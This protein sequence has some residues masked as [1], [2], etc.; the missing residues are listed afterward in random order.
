MRLALRRS[1]ALLAVALVAL[2][3]GIWVGS[4]AASEVPSFEQMLGLSPQT[5]PIAP[6]APSE[7]EGAPTAVRAPEAEGRPSDHPEAA[8]ASV[9]PVPEGF[10][11]YS[12][13]WIHFA[14]QP[15]SRARVEPLKAAADGVRAELR[16]I[17]GQDVL[18]R[19]HVRVGRTVGEMRTL[20]PPGTGFPK[21][22]SGVAYSE[23]GLVLLSEQSRYPN[24][25]HDLLQVFRHELAHVALHDAVG[26][27][28]VPRWF[29]EGFAVHAS[30]E[31]ITARMQTLWTATLAGKLLP[32]AELT[33]R[34]PADGTT[35]SVAYAQA[36]DVVRY[37]LRTHEAHRFRALIERLRSG[38]SFEAALA[39]AY[40]TDLANLEYEWREDVARRY[41]FWPVL[42]SGTMVW[43]GAILLVFWGWKRR[44]ARNQKILARWAVEE[45]AEDARLAA[46]TEVRP[47]HIVLARPSEIPPPPSGERP[48]RPDVPKIEHDGNWHTLH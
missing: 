7:Q 18:S 40:A 43:M 34:F 1:L 15:A 16:E 8:G 48:G 39:D 19:A 25:Q 2:L 10:S 27:Q 36:A 42:F 4:A 32:L 44:R 24:D 26:R 37:L 6:F 23:I 38:Q 31:A 45:A 13:G 30:G 5:E 28:N 17:L 9:P 29:N 46:A 12:A 21:Y 3:G 11:S 20:A 35:A 47:V 22:A 41:T 33:H 14:Y